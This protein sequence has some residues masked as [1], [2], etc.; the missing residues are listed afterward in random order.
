MFS[1][2]GRMERR[3]QSEKVMT[4]F[5][6]E[7]DARNDFCHPLIDITLDNLVNLSSQ[8]FCH[9]HPAAFYECP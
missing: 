4:Y 9:L 5:V 2:L 3:L 7:D 8:F 6:D 1:K